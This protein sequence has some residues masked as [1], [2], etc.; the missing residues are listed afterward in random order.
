MIF[1]YKTKGVCSRS[2]TLDVEGNVI[3]SVSFE[4]GCNGNTKGIAA[5]IAGMDVDDAIARLEGTTCGFK[6]TSCPDQLAQALKVYK[7]E[8]GE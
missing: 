3:K 1:T 5:L 7:T 8:K 2:I 4:G 6:S